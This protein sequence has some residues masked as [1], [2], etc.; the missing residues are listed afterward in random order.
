MPDIRKPDILVTHRD[1]EE[2][3][4]VAFGDTELD[5]IIFHTDASIGSF[6]LKQNRL[7]SKHKLTLTHLHCQI[8]R[9]A[10][11]PVSGAIASLLEAPIRRDGQSDGHMETTIIVWLN[12]VLQEE[13]MK[14]SIPPDAYATDLMP[15]DIAISASGGPHIVVSRVCTR[16]VFS[17]RFDSNA[18]PIE[19]IVAMKGG[20]IA[21]SSTRRLLAVVE[22]DDYG[23]HRTKV[24]Y[25]GLKS[26]GTTHPTPTL[27]S[28]LDRNP[29]AM[30]ISHQDDKVLLALSEGCSVGSV[31]P[32]EVL[33]IQPD[34]RASCAYRVVLE[35]PCRLLSF[36]FDDPN[37]IVTAR[38][39]GVVSLHNLLRGTT[40]IHHD[41]ANIR[42]VCVSANHQLILSAYDNV[43]HVYKASQPAA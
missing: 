19:T 34:G 1:K 25:Y 27:V 26:F 15:S 41:D 37:F 16:K 30:A 14:L 12:G 43:F 3:H 2:V 42:S 13:P 39:D 4:G 31:L 8:R 9:M 11:N 7:V 21:I 18:N 23:N 24:W 32:V 5:K 17:W 38:D 22:E 6:I 28:S 36:C 10:V 35:S 29:R 33:A 20:L 40:G